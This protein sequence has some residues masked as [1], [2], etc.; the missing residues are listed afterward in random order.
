MRAIWMLMVLFPAFALAQERMMDSQPLVFSRQTITI[1]PTA[2]EPPPATTQPAKKPELPPL[3][4]IPISYSIE[5]R[6]ERDLSLDYIDSLYR[7]SE[8]NGVLFNFS[9]P[10]VAPLPRFQVHHPT[11][12][13]F[14]D[15]QGVIV[16]ILPNHVPAETTQDIMAQEPIKAWIYLQV[17]QVANRNIK[18]G[19]TVAGDMFTPAPPIMRQ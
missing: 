14:V 2:P 6:G 18:P 16:Q 1:Q 8:K 13:L 4:R 12:V 15:E 11:D 5:L 19:D 10:T 7:L 9:A 17:G 3:P